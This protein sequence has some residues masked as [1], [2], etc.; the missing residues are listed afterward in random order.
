MAKSPVLSEENFAELTVTLWRLHQRW[1]ESKKKLTAA[2]EEQI[3]AK[4]SHDEVVSEIE[5]V[6]VQ[7]LPWCIR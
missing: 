2:N 4:N 7:L 1:A 5:A 6:H 3:R